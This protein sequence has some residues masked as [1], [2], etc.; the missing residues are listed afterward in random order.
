MKKKLKMKKRVFNKDYLFFLYIIPSVAQKEK[1][2]EYNTRKYI[3]TYTYKV[4][5][6]IAYAEKNINS[7]TGYACGILLR[8]SRYVGRRCG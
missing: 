4:K 6:C 3:L 7:D 5:G 2:I 1:G 8:M